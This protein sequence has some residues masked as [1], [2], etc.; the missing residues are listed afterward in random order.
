MPRII[1]KS[2]SSALILV[3]LV[4]CPLYARK[5]EASLWRFVHPGSKALVGIQWSRVQKSE[6]GRWIEQ[7]WING[8]SIPGVEFLKNIDEVLISSPG[9][10]PGSDDS[11][12]PLLIALQGTFDL[13]KVR[14]VLMLQHFRV[15]TF[16]G[17]PIY[18]KLTASATEPAFALIDSGTI[19]IGDPQSLFSTIESSRSL[20]DE[21]PDAFLGRAQ[22]LSTRYD[23]W[24][25]MSDPSAMKNFLFS[26]L[27]GQTLTPDSQ[28]FEAGISVKDGLAIDVVLSL[29]NE[30]AARVLAAKLSRTVRMAAASHE[31]STGAVGL[32]QKF[33]V[34]LDRSNVMMS[35]RM[36]PAETA[37]S[38]IV[39]PHPAAASVTAQA[40][41]VPA[42]G[43]KRV[44]RIEGLD[45]GPREII[46][47]QN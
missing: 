11:E 6:V 3:S 25:V 7:R 8:E 39:P 28:G 4:L 42:P 12:P 19:L 22:L 18:R 10:T 27:A 37:A 26:S 5:T 20:A 32:F 9:T 46:L 2:L 23:C 36:N 13:A 24:A 43:Q 16:N 45:D 41:A 17:A 29:T 15:Q 47:K 44:I 1:V 34:T 33:R 38:L 35:V 40:R 31:D 21:E 30:H 14:Q